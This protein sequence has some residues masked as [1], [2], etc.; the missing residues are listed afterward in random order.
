MKPSTRRIKKFSPDPRLVAIRPVS[1]PVFPPDAS[2]RALA[3]RSHQ[4]DSLAE[5]NCPL[6]GALGARAWTRLGPC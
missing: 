6:I 1:N 5:E 2:D 3:K 4:N